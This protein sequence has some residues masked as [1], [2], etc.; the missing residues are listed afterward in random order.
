LDDEIIS[1]GAR[2]TRRPLEGIVWVAV[3]RLMLATNG[4]FVSM[5]AICRHRDVVFGARSPSDSAS[6]ML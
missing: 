6:N 1:D 4:N 5:F 2:G 3:K